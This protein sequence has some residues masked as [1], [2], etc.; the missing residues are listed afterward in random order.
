MK[1]LGKHL[2]HEISEAII[3]EVQ[4]AETFLILDFFLW[5]EWQ[6]RFAKN[7]GQELTPL[8]NQLADAII[9]KRRANP[10]CRFLSLP[11]QSIDFMEIRTH[12]FFNPLKSWVYRLFIRIYTN[13]L[14]RI[15]YT[16]S[17]SVFGQ[18]FMI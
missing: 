2:D 6:G 7:N 18:N 5:N 3:Q 10:K 11:I 9:E 17:K 4:S 16:P 12:S 14:T 8:G 15:K 13:Y 1:R